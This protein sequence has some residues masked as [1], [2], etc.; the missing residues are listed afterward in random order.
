MG[1]ILSKPKIPAPEP[2]SEETKEAQ[3][4]QQEILEADEKK[5][6]LERM[7]E[8]TSLQERKRRAR[9]GGRRTLLAERETPEIGLGQQSDTLG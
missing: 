7:K 1:A 5:A 9:Y 6:E 3:K 2:I 8:M 4:R